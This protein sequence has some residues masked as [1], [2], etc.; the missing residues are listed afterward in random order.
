MLALLPVLLLAS[1][2]NTSAPKPAVAAVQLS[3]GTLNAQG[4][5]VLGTA[6]LMRVKLPDGTAPQ[7]AVPVTIIGA[8][9]LERRQAADSDI[10]GQ[11]G[12]L[13]EVGA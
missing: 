12:F 3:A 4:E 1:C 13:L 8:E 2:S 9:R 10:H 6:F 5:D 7:Q 11:R